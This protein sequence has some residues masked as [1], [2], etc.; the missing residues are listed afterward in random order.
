MDMDK[1]NDNIMIPVQ[2]FKGYTIDEIKYLRTITLLRREFCKERIIN[3]THDVIANNPLT[4]RKKSN[5]GGNILSSPILGKV[6]KGFSYADYAIMGF[7]VFKSVKSFVS[8]FR[9]K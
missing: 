8:L 7:N 6:L 4:G 3:R 1:N 9:K 5:S 2:S